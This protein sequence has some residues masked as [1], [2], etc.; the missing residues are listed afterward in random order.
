MRIRIVQRPPMCVVDGIKLE[1]YVPGQYYDMGQTL[2]A[3]FLAEGWGVPAGDDATRSAAPFSDEDPYLTRVSDGQ[4][5]PNLVRETPLR[6]I[7]SPDA[8]D[9]IERRRRPR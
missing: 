9:R 8:A 6:S 7:G 2:A 3:L 4:T 5:P 1:I